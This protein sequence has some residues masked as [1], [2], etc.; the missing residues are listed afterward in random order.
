MLKALVLSLSL[1]SLN[2]WAGNFALRTDEKDPAAAK[3]LKEV[4]ALIPVQMKNTID[5]TINVK[6]TNLNGKKIER[7]NESCDQKL[8]LGQAIRMVPGQT[9]G[10]LQ[11]DRV[12]LDGVTNIKSI[13]CSHKDTLTYAKAIAIHE[14]SHFYDN[15]VNASTDATFLNMSGWISKGVIIKKRTN[16]N[17][18]TQRSPDVYEYKNPAETF[19]VNF[20]FFMLDKTFQCRRSSYY[21][22]YS[23]LL[24]FSPYSA[25]E[26]EMNK[27][28]TLITQ[29][30]EKKPLL[31]KEIDASR[32]YQIHYLFAG[33]G[34]EMM[35]RWGHAMFR[36][37]I[38]APGTPVGPQC[39]QDIANHIVVSY[40]ANI[41]EMTM[42]Y[43]KGIDGSYASQL[44]LMS[45]NDVVNE[46]T[47]GE[48]RDVISLP[49][50]LNRG[51]IKLFTDK[52][53]ES[54]WS[55]K[56]SYFFIT[57]NC[58]S[59]AMNLLRAAYPGDKLMQKQSITTPLGMYDFLIKQKLVNAN[60]IDNTKEAIY[61][62][63]LFPGVSEKLMASLKVFTSNITFEKFALELKAPER[64][65]IYEKTLEN[66]S[67]KSRMNALAH[68]LRL[69]DQILVSR[70][71]TFAKKVGE[72]LFGNNASEELKGT[73]L[74]ERMMQIRD[75][76]KKLAGE[77]FITKGYG[78]PL[79]EEFNDVADSV[80][81]EVLAVIQGNSEELKEI[82][83]QYFPEELEEMKQT[84]ENRHFL[85][86]GISKAF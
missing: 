80:A 3:L 59:E 37:V 57:N 42:D 40:R 17:T 21:N 49:I 29:T 74:D 19:A 52:L 70:E 15:Q 4:E 23:K 9:E 68:A 44:F 71:Q 67:G 69:E 1:V 41:D 73:E 35:S 27:K 76:Y 55:Y 61:Y 50:E 75:E 12:L 72:A 30:L 64:K 20:E 5:A 77:N 56:G 62:G 65:A 79:K 10:Y 48:F 84:M 54:Y 45:M 13:S 2:A 16:L 28:I 83:A 60:V 81:E 63:Y 32:I 6:F 38:C 39:L 86:T 14:I 47:K 11:L 7:L 24:G 78:V 46:Y 58:A 31:T 33:K 53:L 36:L 18:A 51:Q 26:C 85:L 43:K 34:K 22:Y 25:S 82:V 66:L 8:V